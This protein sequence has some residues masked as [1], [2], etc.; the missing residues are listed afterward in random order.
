[1]LDLPGV[2]EVDAIARMADPVLRNLRITQCYQEL[3]LAFAA[4]SGRHANWCTFATWASKQAGQTIRGEDLARLLEGGRGAEPLPVEAAD[5]VAATALALGARGDDADIHA[6]LREALDPAAAVERASAAVGRGNQKVFE[7]IAREF[8]RFGAECLA[9]TSSDHTRIE[10]FCAMLRPGGPPEGQALLRQAFAHYY[11]ALF[12]PDAKARLELLLLANLEIGWHE[13]TRLQPEIAAALDAG[14]VDPAELRRRV[15]ASSFPFRGWVVRM[16]LGVS[17]FIGGPTPLDRAIDGLVA[18]A[19]QRARLAITEHMMRLTLP[20]DLRLR[21]G[22][23]LHAPFPAAL[24]EI[25]NPELRALLA[26]VDPTPDRLDGSGAVDWADLAERLHFI[27]DMFR[28]FADTPS[29][30]EPPFA[31]E[32]VAA[33]RAGQVPGGAL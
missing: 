1:M 4:R 7:E 17:R 30:F 11:R 10:R 24:R 9:D 16:R 25:A 29:L 20:G 6:V 14:F 21:L 19:R 15:L 22:E 8:A 28:C 26:Q 2:A 5:E 27:T 23:D 33:I 13:Q 3:S 32:Q 18:L 12:E 31:P